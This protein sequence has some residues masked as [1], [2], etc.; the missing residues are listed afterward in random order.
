MNRYAYVLIG[1]WDYDGFKLI[2]VYSTEAKAKRAEKADKS[3]CHWYEISKRV[4][5]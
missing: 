2:G 1:A 5:Q 3:G 4:I